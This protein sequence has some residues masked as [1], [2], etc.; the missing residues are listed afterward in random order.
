MVFGDKKSGVVSYVIEGG[1]GN[2]VKQPQVTPPS[3][4]RPP[5]GPSPTKQQVVFL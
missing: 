3:I 2:G 5:L 4:N 1:G